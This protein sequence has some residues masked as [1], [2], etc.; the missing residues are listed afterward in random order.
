MTTGRARCARAVHEL[1]E[2]RNRVSWA[3]FDLGGAHDG[4]GRTRAA[5]IRGRARG[6]RRSTAGARAGPGPRRRAASPRA[7]PSTTSRS[8]APRG[9]PPP[10][11]RPRSPSPRSRSRSGR[12]ARRRTRAP[13]PR[14]EIEL[15]RDG[16]LSDRAVRPDRHDL[17]V[18][19]EIRARWHVQA[20]RRSAQVSQLDAVPVPR[21]L[22]ILETNSWR[23]LDVEAV[24][25][26][27]VQSSRQAAGTVLLG[28]HSDDRDGGTRAGASSTV[29]TIGMPR[30][31]RRACGV[32]DRHR[33][34][35]AVADDPAHRLAVVRV[36]REALSEDQDAPRLGAHDT[37]TE[38]PRPGAAATCVL[39]RARRLGRDPRAG[40]G[41][42]PGRRG[43]RAKR[44][45]AA[46][47]SPDSSMHPSITPRPSARAACSSPPP[48]SRPTSR[49]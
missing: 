6:S 45:P 41:C 49:A 33:R 22:R 12:S 9:S 30:A 17:R 29:P 31:L 39:P 16:L 20:G 3:P 8:A 2:R 21:Q 46:M 34:V 13:A 32:E 14:L 25:I 23:H 44:Q 18:D 42:R 40:A 24:A 11:R 28:R 15:D 36:V 48:G 4:R 7:A 43:R 1:H 19:L 5:P 47:P 38:T 10:P 26:E 27:L 35:R 37:G